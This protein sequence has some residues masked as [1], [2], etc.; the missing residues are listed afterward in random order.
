MA[1]LSES[2]MRQIA[3]EEAEKEVS[4]ITKSLN[5]KIDEIVKCNEESNKILARLERLLL[6][7]EGVDEQDTL[8]ARA[9]FAY[10]HAKES[11]DSRF[12]ERTLPVIQWYEDMERIPRG[13]KHSKLDS[14]GKIINL[15]DNISWLLGIIGIATIFNAIPVIKTII[16]WIS[17]FS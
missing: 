15:Y 14:L 4:R 9:L 13:D 11:S 16:D 10:A 7:E 12:S 5:R 17:N 3:K 6:G 1:E 8:R 2:K